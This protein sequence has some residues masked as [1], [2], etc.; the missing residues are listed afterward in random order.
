VY[1]FAIVNIVLIYF[2]INLVKSQEA[3]F[4]FPNACL[5]RASLRKVRVRTKHI[6][7]KQW[8]GAEAAAPHRTTRTR[9]TDSNGIA[10]RRE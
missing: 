9:I 3:N 8:R 6:V 2:S 4:F 1:L 5:A 7:G 10:D